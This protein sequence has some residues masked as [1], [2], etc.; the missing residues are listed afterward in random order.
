MFGLG[1]GILGG[2]ATKQV[3]GSLLLGLVGGYCFYKTAGSLA[4]TPAQAVIA[5]TTDANPPNVDPTELGCKSAW[6]QL[7]DQTWSCDA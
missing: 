3:T 6:K 7:A 4:L 2:W 1:L 5:T